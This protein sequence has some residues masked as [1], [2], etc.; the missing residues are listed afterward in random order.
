ML[1]VKSP[2]GSLT[3]L[4][5]SGRKNISRSGKLGA[6]ATALLQS[7][8]GASTNSYA[9]MSQ[10]VSPLSGRAKPRWSVVIGFG[11]GEA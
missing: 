1:M 10:P 8:V 5:R 9:P 11:V 2:F 4:T 7:I 3:P 6:L